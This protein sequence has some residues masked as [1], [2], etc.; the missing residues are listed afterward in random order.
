MDGLHIFIYTGIH[1]EIQL[2]SQ[3]EDVT[4]P[5]GGTARFNCTYQGTTEVPFWSIG[6]I[7]YPIDRLPDRHVYMNQVLI[8][9]NVL[10]SDS[11]KTY[12]CSFFEPESRIATLTVLIP[13]GKEC[14]SYII[15][16]LFTTTHSY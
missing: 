2:T 15:A 6:S 7:V 12:Q 8:V 10:A 3:P 1:C 9:T 13:E 11:G 14:C 16:K 5:I 4:V